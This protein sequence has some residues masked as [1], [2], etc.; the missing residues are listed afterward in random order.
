MGSL[1]AFVAGGYS[2]TGSVDRVN[3]QDGTVSKAT[4][5]ASR[6]AF[7][8]NK[9][10]VAASN[11]TLSASDSSQQL[12]IVDPVGM[13][14]ETT[15]TSQGIRTGLAT[16]GTSVYAQ[17]YSAAPGDLLEISLLSDSITDTFDV[18]GM[19]TAS[20]LTYGH[21]SLWSLRS[22][23]DAGS[24][25]TTM[26]IYRIN[27]SDGSID[28]D[29]ST[30]NS[31]T[32]QVFMLSVIATD[33]AVYASDLQE[34]IYKIDPATDTITTTFNVRSELSLTG[35]A[36]VSAVDF[37]TDGSSAF[38][39]TDAGGLYEIDTSDNFTTVNA[40]AGD[41]ALTY[42]DGRLYVVDGLA[43]NKTS[44]KAYDPT[45]GTEVVSYDWT[46]GQGGFDVIVAELSFTTGIFVGA[47]VF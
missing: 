21:G 11:P 17:G 19:E 29:I 41:G 42:Y 25:F 18:R 9:V 23:N 44:L 24:Y 16:I 28:A 13:T 2:G 34:R 46:G 36:N 35:P 32:N 15:L 14:I 39:I 43:P 8:N 20:N 1:Y 4:S 38:F 5:N 33:T 7:S 12:Q 40:N 30:G 27:P 22:T 31:S 26:R 45:D 3:L 47:V 6:V 37:A 10:L